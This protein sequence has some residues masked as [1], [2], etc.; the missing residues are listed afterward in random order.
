[1]SRNSTLPK[2]K[3][4]VNFLYF[5][6][7]DF[8]LVHIMYLILICILWYFFKI[9]FSFYDKIVSFPGK[10]RI[11]TYYL[12]KVC[13]KIWSLVELQ[14][15]WYPIDHLACM[16]CVINVHYHWQ[17]SWRSLRISFLLSK[18]SRTLR[19]KLRIILTLSWFSIILYHHKMPKS[20]LLY[21]MK[22]NLVNKIQ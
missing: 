15:T 3:D 1:M 17:W 20:H 19:T 21:C 14:S 18:T 4:N 16:S 11:C 6:L 13:Y 8:H 5:F 22:H 9:F 12:H 7:I 10:W 2:Q